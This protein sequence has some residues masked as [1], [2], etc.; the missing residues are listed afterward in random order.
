MSYAAHMG[1]TTQFSFKT[2]HEQT[3]FTGFATYNVL[4]NYTIR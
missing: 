2:G 1:R 4:G 3:L